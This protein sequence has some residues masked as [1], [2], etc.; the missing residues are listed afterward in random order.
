MD[1]QNP[2]GAFQPQRASRQI[3]S[4][5]RIGGLVEKV[6]PGHVDLIQVPFVILPML[7]HGDQYENIWMKEM[8]SLL[9]NSA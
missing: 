9:Q 1:R 7:C 4:G 6:F 3:S 2:L 5:N 8:F